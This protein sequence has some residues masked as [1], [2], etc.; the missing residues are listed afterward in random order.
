MRA[1]AQTLALLCGLLLVCAPPFAQ[2]DH[3]RPECDNSGRMSISFVEI[4]SYD[5]LT[6]APLKVKGKLTLPG[7]WYRGRCGSHRHKVPA[8]VILHGS[9]GIDF[10]GNFYAE[11]LNRAGIATLEIDMWEA[12]DVASGADRPPLP[13]YTYPDAFASLAFLADYPGID[14][15]RI[16]VLGFSWGAVMAMASAT[17]GVVAQFGVGQLQFKAHVA[18]YPICYAYNNP[19]IRNSDFGASAG[20][21]LTGA[22]ILIEV[23]SLDDYD[24][25]AGPCLALRAGLTEEERA[26]VRVNVYD[27]AYHA[28]D[29]L[30]VP[31]TEQD[32][33]ANLGQGGTV[34]LVP[35]VED[36]YLSR[37]RVVKFFRRNL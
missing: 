23:G 7:D 10:R 14:A 8:V 6:R 19:N 28:W 13:L 11:A 29:R 34:R 9:A 2:A 36:A 25:G 17:Q 22:P 24:K 35:D 31:T 4:D 15:Q 27:G 30:L 32:P 16:G 20:N 26:L 21:P 18:H 37:E 12:R 3:R 1:I 33:F 5:F